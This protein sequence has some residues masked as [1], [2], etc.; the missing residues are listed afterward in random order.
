[1]HVIAFSVSMC[2]HVVAHFDLSLVSVPQ[3]AAHCTNAATC[4]Y[5]L[6]FTDPSGILASP[7]YPLNVWVSI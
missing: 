1:L 4:T 2:A 3:D 7:S 6:R 5:W